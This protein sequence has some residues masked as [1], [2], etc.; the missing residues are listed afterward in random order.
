MAFCQGVRKLLEQDFSGFNENVQKRYTEIAGALE[1]CSRIVL[2]VAHVGA[3]ISAHAMGALTDL[4]SDDS[5]GEERLRKDP[6]IFDAPK[7]DAALR[8]SKAVPRVDATLTIRQ[9]GKVSDP[10]TTYFGLVAVPELVA[11]YQK[12]G[13]ALFE[14]NIR[15]FL[16]QA[17]DVNVSI[18]QTLQNNPDHFVYLNNGVTALCQRIDPKGNKM[19]C[20]Q[21]KIGGLSIVNGAQT[22]ASCA[23]F[24]ADHK[25]ADISKARVSIT[26]VETPIDGDFGKSVTRARNHQNP[27]LL[28][29]FVALDEEQERLRRD[30]AHLGIHYAYKAGAVDGIAAADLIRAEEAVHALAL[31]HPDPRYVSWLKKEPATLLDT[32]A[33]RYKALFTPTLT[34][35]QLANA[36]K[37]VRYTF[38][39]MADEARG[40]G[41]E[42]LTYKHGVYAFTWMLARQVEAERSAAK[43]LDEA[44]I[45]AQ[46]SATSDKVR[47][48]LW[49][50]THAALA[51]YRSPLTVFRSQIH[52]L[53]VMTDVL[54]EHYALGEDPAVIALKNQQ[55]PKL[56]YAAKL[57]GY[58]ISKAPQIQGLA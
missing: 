1:N 17:T 9:C 38:R 30:L 7:I 24:V 37:F 27:V 8:A 18:R 39:L 26:L 33:D 29:N 51:G 23:Q 2:I 32:T 5:H 13:K 14:K 15:T 22:I 31:F 36:V 54:I 16:G 35:F 56:A 40:T 47:Q 28:A 6:E 12:H 46:L 34:A 10:K 44:K 48:L 49:T 55:D 19:E 41:P 43:L 25:D 20:K 11:L 21:L 50:K 57:F 3:G 4:L 53:P 58:L 42:K 45:A 52:A